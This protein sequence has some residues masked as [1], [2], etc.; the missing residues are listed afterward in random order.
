MVIVLSFS[1]TP[2][3][4][5]RAAPGALATPTRVQPARRAAA[6]PRSRSGRTRKAASGG[7]E[8]RA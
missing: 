4:M 6:A 8:R 1:L 7:S 3:E 5:P 2:E